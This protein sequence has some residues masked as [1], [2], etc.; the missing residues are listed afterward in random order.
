MHKYHLT[1]RHVYQDY[2]EMAMPVST[3]IYQRTT[4]S[5]ARVKECVPFCHWCSL[6]ICMAV[7]STSNSSA[8]WI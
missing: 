4:A 2:P 1:L 7:C 3:L 5:E 6:A 8:G